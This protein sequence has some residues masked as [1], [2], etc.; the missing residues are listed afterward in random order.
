MGCR[1]ICDAIWK[2]FEVA[3]KWTIGVRG[4]CSRSP[5]FFVDVPACVDAAPSRSPVEM[6][7][8]CAW[9]REKAV[10][11]SE[12]TELAARGPVPPSQ[13]GPASERGVRDGAAST[14]CRIRKQSSSWR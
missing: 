8:W 3:A 10:G 6:P 5:A 2:I 7:T 13:R 11:I 14:R 1:A 9:P 12:L 4:N